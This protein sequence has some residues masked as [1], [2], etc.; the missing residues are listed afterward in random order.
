VR[1]FRRD[2]PA[3]YGRALNSCLMDL[4]RNFPPAKL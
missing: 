2:D 1:A 4:Y 3:L